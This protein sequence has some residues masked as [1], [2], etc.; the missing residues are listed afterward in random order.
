VI[1]DRHPVANCEFYNAASTAQSWS[2]GAALSSLPRAPSRLRGFS[3]VAG[4]QNQDCVLDG[5]GRGFQIGRAQVNQRPVA[6]NSRS[7][8]LPAFV[9]SG[10][11]KAFGQTC[12]SF[13]DRLALIESCAG[14]SILATR[15]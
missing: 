4:E 7:T 13:A 11:L 6:V 12:I 9:V 5:G 14:I 8:S 1:S 3:Q 2:P 15:Q 10:K